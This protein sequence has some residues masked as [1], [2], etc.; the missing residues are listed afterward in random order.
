MGELDAAPPYQPNPG[1]PG[2]QP[3]PG[4]TAGGLPPMSP[5]EEDRAA[6]YFQAAGEKAK[7]LVEAFTNPPNQPAPPK[8]RDPVS[9]TRGP[10]SP[11][12]RAASGPSA[13]ANPDP[14]GIKGANAQMLG[15]YDQQAA[16]LGHLADA[17]VG[18]ADA[19]GKQHAEMARRMRED[20][21]IARAEDEHAAQLTDKSIAEIS[22]QMDDVRTKRLKPT[23]LMAESPGLGIAAIIGGVLG[24]LYQSLNHLQE[25]PFLKTLD[26]MIDRQ[27]AVDEKNLENQKEGL[28]S[29]MNLLGQQRQLFRD[30]ATAKA[31]YRNVM[32]E[33]F[34]EDLKAASAPFD[35][36]MYRANTEKALADLKLAQGGLQRQ[37]GKEL[38]SQ[39]AAGAAA[40]FAK[41]K[42]VREMRNHVYDQVL[43]ETGSPAI[44][45]AEADRQMAHVYY[46]ELVGT[47]APGSEAQ[48]MTMGRAGREK[49]AAERFETQHASDEFNSQVDALKKHPALD[50][51]GV[52]TGMTAK[53][54]PRIAPDSSAA[55]QDL[56]QIN[57]QILQAIGKVAKD[58]DGKP[59]K[60]MIDKLE[61]EFAI[62][63]D[64]TKPRALQKLEG[65]RSTVNALARQQ[66]ATGAPTP[67]AAQDARDKLGAKPMGR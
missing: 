6:A 49:I 36:P 24:G 44:A 14:Y 12:P 8:P 23:S 15:S 48:G 47:R 22:R 62:E 13:P 1:A 51:L 39:A 19:I 27:L 21:E 32:Y 56:A 5:E 60:A 34:A 67:S 54:G 2:Y 3:N 30:H 42:E 20:A 37:L 55:V 9:M 38:Q 50:K 18:R 64:D 11:P 63:P 52:T 33:A 59:N 66:G 40:Q 46:P 57:T 61:K 28:R 65:A 58:A 35:S 45:E 31:A 26:T 7:P 17:E 10:T 25:N 16:A 29:K 41:A 53:L 43:K 4:A